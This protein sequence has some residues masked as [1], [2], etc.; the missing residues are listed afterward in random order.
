MSAVVRLRTLWLNDAANPADAVSFPLMSELQ[1]APAIRGE[2][3]RY[4]G[5]RSRSVTRKG[6]TRPV[7][8]TLANC[9]RA[10][11]AWLE[12]HIGLPVFVR[13]DR[14]RRLVGTYLEVPTAEHPYDDE[15]DVALQVS[16]LS[17]VEEV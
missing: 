4:A 15:A 14:G 16:E 7:E 8:A 13:D 12:A 3:H 1:V 2:V 10:Q 17:L 5:G 11:V 6:V 9:T